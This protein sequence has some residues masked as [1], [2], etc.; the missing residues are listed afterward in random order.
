M[1]KRKI[2]KRLIYLFPPSRTTAHSVSEMDAA[3]QTNPN[4]HYQPVKAVAKIVRTGDLEDTRKQLRFT[5]LAR[6]TTMYYHPVFL[7]SLSNTS[8][9]RTPWNPPTQLIVSGSDPPPSLDPLDTEHLTGPD[10]DSSRY[11]FWRS[12]TNFQLARD[13]VSWAC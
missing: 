10:R 12:S 6:V 7:P 5:M 11:T 4:T 8:C 9:I 1:E 3:N 13:L 2:E